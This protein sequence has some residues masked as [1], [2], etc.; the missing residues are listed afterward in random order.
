M[1]YR[2]RSIVAK[3]CCATR[4]ARAP[5][6]TKEMWVTVGSPPAIEARSI[7]QFAPS[8]YPGLKTASGARRMV[9]YGLVVACGTNG[10]AA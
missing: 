9:G 3:S 8:L 2:S 1:T 7:D 5:A 4:V 6:E 10:E